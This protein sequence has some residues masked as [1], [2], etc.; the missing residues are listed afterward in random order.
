MTMATNN[1]AEEILSVQAKAQLDSEKP[2]A[3]SVP[4]SPLKLELDS[5]KATKLINLLTDGLV[6]IRD[7]D[8]R[9]LLKLDDGTLIDTKGWEHPT[10]FSWE[11]THGIALTA[12]CHHSAISPTSPASQKSLDT[13]MAWFNSQYSRTSGK[14]APK[15]IN[16]FSPFY[17][18]ASFLEDGR[19]MDEQGKWRAWCED[20]GEWVMRDDGLPKTQEGGFQHI[21]YANAH[22]QNLWDDTLMMSAIPLAKLGIL[23]NQPSWIDEAVYQFLL[24]IRYLSDPVTGLWYHGWEF[25]PDKR[26]RAAEL[27]GGQGWKGGKNGHN[28][29]RAFWARGNCWITL[30]IPMLLSILSPSSSSPHPKPLH[31]TDPTARFLIQTW[32]RQVDALIALQDPNS[33]M[34]HTLLDDPE[35]YVETSA[36]AGFVAGIYMGL[37]MNLLPPSKSISYRAAADVALAAILTQ[38]QPDGQVANVSFGTGMGE[39]LQ[40]YRDIAITPMPYGQALVMH[41]LVEWERLNEVGEE[42]E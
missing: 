13:A 29:A 15:N 39:T 24:H 9:F 11:W 14:G 41:A 12:L 26:G 10:V 5:D 32:T 21:T 7:E 4:S 17:A 27:E 28:F 20:W 18:L 38:I 25:T 2:H 6:S 37:R 33:G 3:S 1:T 22:P 35:S 30:A 42:C 36:S 34:W 40:F 31:P 23:L 19:E 8:G 16:T